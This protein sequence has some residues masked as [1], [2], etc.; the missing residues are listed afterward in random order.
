MNIYHEYP[1]IMWMKW[2][3][4]KHPFPKNRGS[5]R[6]VWTSSFAHCW[7]PPLGVGK[8]VGRLERQMEASLVDNSDRS[9]VPGKPAPKWRPEPWPRDPKT[10]RWWLDFFS[11]R[12]GPNG[13]LER[14]KPAS[15]DESVWKMALIWEKNSNKSAIWE[16][17]IVDTTYISG[18]LED[19]VLLFYPHGHHGERACKRLQWHLGGSQDP[20]A[21]IPQPRGISAEWGALKW[22]QPLVPTGDFHERW[23][24]NPNTPSRWR[25]IVGYLD[26]RPSEY[27]NTVSNVS[28]CKYS[29]ILSIIKPNKHHQIERPP[30][31][32]GPK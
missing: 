24:E 5:P 12:N 27:P 13:L 31:C 23:L 21:S 3:A 6:L 32:Q 16:W 14:L 2:C 10:L 19:G 29:F 17:L 30:G 22:T 28:I 9:F 15:R 8:I 26:S 7:T 4:S 25:I 11:G 20:Y 18:D 1:Y